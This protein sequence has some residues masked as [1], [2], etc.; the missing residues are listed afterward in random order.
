MVL[1]HVTN[2]WFH[3]RLVDFKPLI[4]QPYIE[5]KWLA[6]DP[7]TSSLYPVFKRDK[8]FLTWLL[9]APLVP[10]SANRHDMSRFIHVVIYPLF[11]SWRSSVV[12]GSYMSQLLVHMTAC[13]H[14]TAAIH[15]N[16]TPWTGLAVTAEMCRQHK[17]PSPC[18]LLSS[19]SFTCSIATLWDC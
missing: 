16:P 8:S 3:A 4:H 2:T 17:S 1:C 19:S 12:V 10:P 14:L 13:Y 6:V 15:I 18:L 5:S 7:S 11:C 9:G